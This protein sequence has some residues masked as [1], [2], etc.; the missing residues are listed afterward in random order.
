[1]KRR[2][3]LAL[4]LARLAVLGGATI[5]VTTAP[6]Q[7]ASVT[8]HNIG[9]CGL[10]AGGVGAGLSPDFYAQSGMAQI[11]PGTTMTYGGLYIYY[12]GNPV[13]FSCKDYDNSTPGMCWPSSLLM[14]PN[15]NYDIYIS[16]DACGGS[17]PLYGPI[18][19]S[20][21]GASGAGSG[22][23][24]GGGGWPP[25]P[26]TCGGGAG[27]GPDGPDGP[28]G[29]GNGNGDGD[30]PL[31]DFWDPFSSPTPP[32]SGMPVWR[33]S[34]PYISLWLYDEPL[35]YR[36][37]VG[38]RIALKLDYKQREGA[39]GMDPAIFSL[40]KK[41]NFSWLSYVASVE[42][43]PDG[44]NTFSSNVVYFPG[45]GSRI[46]AGATD[47][48]TNTR[49]TG[50]MTNGYSLYYPDGSVDTYDCIL[51][52]MAFL[53][54]HADPHSQATTFNY[55]TNGFVVQLRSV[56]DAT[57]G[58]NVLYYNSSNAYSTN[59]IT[60]VK[61][62]YNR[63]ALFA[64]DT[65]GCLTNIT[66]VQGLAS[67]L[68]Y[69]T[70]LWVTWLTTPYGTTTF[71]L[72]DTPAIAVPPNGR[73]AL[74]TDP[75][76]S[77]ELYLYQ[78]EATG[79]P[80]TYAGGA[81]P[82]TGSITNMLDNNN[83]EVRNSFHWGKK[84]Y[85]DL[86]SSNI[87]TFTTNDFRL[88]QM[89]HW[90]LTSSDRVG[91]TCSLKR[92]PSPDVLG[93]IDGQ[94]TWYDY[95]GKTNTAY[96]G[97][98]VQPQLVAKV[99]PDGSSAFTRKS[100]NTLGLVTTNINTWSF[101]GAV[102][103][104]TNIY[105]YLP[106]GIDLVTITN[107]LAIQ[108]TSN[109]FNSF[110]EVLTSLDASNELTVRT[111]DPSQRPT[112]VT[113]PNGLITSNIYGSDG[114]LAEQIEVGIATNFY[115]YS[116]GLVVTH[117]DALGLTV[118]NTWDNL[119]RLTSRTYPDGTYTSNQYSYLDLTA[120]KNRLGNWTYYGYDAL[121]HLVAATNALGNYMLFGYC[122]CGALQ[123]IRDALNNYTYY[124]YDN[125]IE[126]TNIV[127]SDNYSVTNNFNLLGQITNSID[128]S[129]ISVT[130]CFDNQGLLFASS[131]T[132]GQMFRKSFD[133]FDRLTNS[134]DEN[135]VV[136][137]QAYDSLNRILSRTYPG[138]GAELW[139][140]TI[141]LN[142]PASYTNQLH[143]PTHYGYDVAGRKV[144][145]TN[146]LGYATLYTYD[147]D[148]DVTIL[149]DQKGNATKWGYDSYGRVTNKTDAAG[150]T[151]LVYQYDSDSR[152]T[153]RWSLARGTTGYAY[154][155]VGNL[156]NVTYP[157]SHSLSFS[158]DGMNRKTSMSDGI[159]TTT[160]TYTK[161]GQVASET[162]PWASD[163]IA[164]AYIDR[165]RGDFDLQQ[166]NASDWIQ[167]Y[168]YDKANRLQAITSPGG[169]FTYAYSSN[170]AGTITS[171]ALVT[172]VVLPNGAFI[173]NNY[174]SDARMIGT[175]LY[176]STLSNL[177]SSVYAYDLGNERTNVTRTGEN[178]VDYA[179][180]AIGEVVADQAYESTGPA[181]LNEQLNYTYDPSGNLTYRTNNALIEKF[182]VD[183]RNQLT[184]NS[185]G[186]RLT[187][188]GTTTS[189]A[190]GGVT[191]NGVAAISYGDSTFAVTNL[192][193][194][195]T[196]TAIAS[197]SY[198]R[199]ATNTV[200]VSLSTNVTFQYDANGNLTS[201]GMRNFAYDDEKQL[202]QVLAS[203]EWMSQFSYDGEMRRRI[204]KDFAWQS[205][206]W[207][208]T[209]AVYYV[210]DGNLVI[211]ERDANNL[212]TVT[213][214]RG[215]DLGG[216]LEGA[217]GI[218]GMLART[219]QA[220][221]QAPLAG[222][223]FYHADANGNITTL[224]D[225]SQAIVAKYLYDPFGNVISKSG[226]LA[227][228]NVY[229]F[230]SK[231]AHDSSGLVYYLY[232]YYDPNLQRWLNRDPN[233]EL[234]FETAR[235]IRRFHLHRP[236]LDG[237]ATSDLYMFVRNRPP[238]EID[239][240]GLVDCAALQ[241]QIDSLYAKVA[242]IGDR[243]GDTAMFEEELERL[244]NIWS[245]YCLPPPGPAPIPDP[246]PINVPTQPPP[247]S[248]NSNL[249]PPNLWPWVYWVAPVF[250]V[251][252]P[253]NPVF[254]F[255]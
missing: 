153:S 167:S 202:T 97:T 185:N 122:S 35:G 39:A 206:A 218:G 225:G 228:A 109:T 216:R 180:D 211:Q 54:Q 103:L 182:Y 220:Y 207:V 184:T 240:F 48:L 110:H 70:N 36:P 204:R 100:R 247:N 25:G 102:A 56:V 40:G 87:A 205:G 246:C 175:W 152:L 239:S 213:Y 148:G 209:K 155:K 11:F 145:E 58:S 82:A 12:L 17:S 229:R 21:D 235:N 66:D 189:P 64:Y 157:L 94:K 208:Q 172:K 33:V 60:Q 51:N 121:R 38:S 71:N 44:N 198:G 166:P 104:R 37:S 7:Y 86:P 10:N 65:N 199:E 169:T 99:L 136:T 79:I 230:S 5:A 210:Y 203:N 76:G 59:L 107:A 236:Y 28:V 32:G 113:L 226:P 217:G 188:I 93:T 138:A 141:N 187:V 171:S 78:D 252:W 227:A 243:G 41:W 154:D 106:N 170:L 222:Q 29:S 4:C 139:G 223:S 3:S 163:T 158:Y 238:N 30:S 221:N 49:L 128:S 133:I 255:L 135:G 98:Q 118:A 197:D 89:K 52:N 24:W 26:P 143:Q 34:E 196:Y 129:G 181:R 176:N 161:A 73:S 95:A 46:F 253:G 112:S 191:V 242:T 57:G 116:N 162:G 165:V 115:N 195:T 23:G 6:A 55:Y 16:G 250:L 123:S 140:Y 45:G 77:S 19:D 15:V 63:S 137:A 156:T 131:N 241:Q 96:E 43:T 215:L 178:T 232:R 105:T 130:N 50:D 245:R 83:L 126:L 132:F 233:G 27:D 62:R 144:A 142:G 2:L 74:V 75:D 114:Y 251:P 22:G 72:A 214:T 1:M 183:S 248:H 80:A 111:Y 190:A 149:T 91:Q 120:I 147:F 47:Y 179:F 254:G 88:A 31:P 9:P 85:A 90:M 117:T 200:T 101:N 174:D 53:T 177:D 168:G 92:T 13:T 194:T 134:V 8:Y 146:A 69:D 219:S 224:I 108:V 192:P 68:S 160:F 173:T 244:E 159:G 124:D 42:Y 119:Q 14:F 193:L 18:D 212:P 151:I 201:D 249:T 237:G 67:S 84:Q 81:L 150:T 186:G 20:A 127:Y 234:G 61:D 164:Y 231:E 125:R